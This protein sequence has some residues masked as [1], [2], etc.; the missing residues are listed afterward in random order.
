MP[1]SYRA[2][3][4]LGLGAH[5]AVIVVL[6]IIPTSLLVVEF[7]DSK[8]RAAIADAQTQVAAAA[9][10]AAEHHRRSAAA[11]RALLNVAALAVADADF[12][13][14]C[15][16]DAGGAAS[17]RVTPDGRIVCDRTGLVRPRAPADAA[18][19]SRPD[20][21]S[22]EYHLLVEGSAHVV[23]AVADVLTETGDVRRIHIRLPFD[24]VAL[25]DDGPL[26]AE[27]TAVTVLHRETG[28]LVLRHIGGRP[29]AAAPAGSPKA[30]WAEVSGQGDDTATAVDMDGV[31]R[32]FGSAE[33]PETGM[34]FMAGVSRDEVLSAA[35]S[36]LIADLA[37]LGGVLAISALLVWLIME[38]T[39]LRAVREIRDAAVA[40]AQGE[41][42]RRLCIS[43]GP[44]ELRELG[45][46]FNEMTAR[47]EHLA[48]HDQLTGLAN[49]RLLT[50]RFDALAAEGRPFAL[51]EIDLDGFKP[52]NDTHGHAVGD[53]ILMDVAARLTDGLPESAVVARAG[54]DEFMILL[55]VDG[56][57]SLREKA[58]LAAEGM[59]ERIA[60]PYPLRG[61]GE[62]SL[63]SSIGLGFWPQNGRSAETLYRSVD[64]ALYRAKRAGRNRLHVAPVVSPLPQAGGKDEVAA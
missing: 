44:I 62:V 49:R 64:E 39:V 15:G 63:S 52:V 32:I 40:T 16:A 20:A 61:G 10:H 17:L 46:A 25:L 30:V 47:L 22:I 29:A 36:E 11:V 24:W 38:R 2:M 43:E 14:A 9:S 37:L 41:Y 26:D 60:R 56:T 8:R 5:L 3:K 57:E 54:G 42:G 50:S 58:V 28:A 33:V 34:V 12:D 48:F 51:L 13:P 6:A 45:D 31:E 19:A 23:L 4:R 59:L 35:E 53:R 1:I 21:L 27:D 7:I 18:T 55:P